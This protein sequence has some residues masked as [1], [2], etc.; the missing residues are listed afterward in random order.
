MRSREE[1]H[2]EILV[3]CVAVIIQHQWVG[4]S[5]ASSKKLLQPFQE[6]FTGDPS[7]WFNVDQLPSRASFLILFDPWKYKQRNKLI[8][9][10]VLSLSPGVS[11]STWFIPFSV[12]TLAT[13]RWKQNTPVSSYLKFL[14][15][16]SDACQ[17]VC[18]VYQKTVPLV[19]H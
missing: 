1:D 18:S 17:S 5:R 15:V 19:V 13:L 4:D 3:T 9:S 16:E 10:D 11:F 2:V 12:N 8:A 14:M 7:I 6:P